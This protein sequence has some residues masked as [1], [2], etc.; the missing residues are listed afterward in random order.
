MAYNYIEHR[1]KKEA[2]KGRTAQK[3]EPEK[4]NYSIGGSTPREENDPC[5]LKRIP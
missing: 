4:R 1:K 2:K 3:K 5:L